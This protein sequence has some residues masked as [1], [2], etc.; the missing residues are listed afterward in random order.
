MSEDK[1]ESVIGQNTRANLEAAKASGIDMAKLFSNKSYG[2]KLYDLGSIMTR[3]LMANDEIRKLEAT[4][5][6]GDFELL[7]PI[8]RKF[9]IKRLSLLLQY[10]DN[11]ELELELAKIIEPVATTP[12]PWAGWNSTEEDVKKAEREFREI[13]ARVE[14]KIPDMGHDSTVFFGMDFPKD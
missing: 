14:R 3:I 4:I 11:L 10:R 5:P 12:Q 9:F 6:T 2:S 1:K 7:S 13:P 8:R